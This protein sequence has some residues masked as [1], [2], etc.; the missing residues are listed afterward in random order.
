MGALLTLAA[1]VAAVQA[2]TTVE[3]P[4]DR[5]SVE[6]ILDAALE[7]ERAHV[8]HALVRRAVDRAADAGYEELRPRLRAVSERA[9]ADAQLLPTLHALWRLGEPLEWFEELASGED[10]TRARTA[11]VALSWRAEPERLEHY[12]RFAF[13]LGVWSGVEHA[14]ALRREVESLGTPRAKIER[15][16]VPVGQGFRARVEDSISG[17][18]VLPREWYVVEL[19]YGRY[20]ASAVWA[21]E[22]LRALSAA[23]PADAVLSLEAIER[24][25]LRREHDPRLEERLLHSYRSY[26]AT[27][28]AEPA[29]RLLR[30]A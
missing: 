13:E 26:L 15:L 11:F 24:A 4:L 2:P 9:E 7:V 27:F 22:T 17:F 23:H 8:D 25:P 12:D 5:A 6:R 3:R 21:Q 28:L 30:D 1:V 20:S 14:A 29:R 18:D 10:P 19:E 16:W